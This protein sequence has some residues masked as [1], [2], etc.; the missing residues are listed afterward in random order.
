MTWQF[1]RSVLYRR[2]GTPCVRRQLRAASV[3][4]AAALDDGLS[5]RKYGQKDI[6]GAK[7]PR[8]ARTRHSLIPLHCCCTRRLLD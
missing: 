3:Q 8:S 6:L 1:D 2:K 7:Y 4:D 5:W